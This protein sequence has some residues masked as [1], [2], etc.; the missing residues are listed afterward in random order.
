MLDDVSM[1]EDRAWKEMER[2][3][4]KSIKIGREILFSISF[5]IGVLL[6][7]YNY[8]VY[9]KVE[10]YSPIFFGRIYFFLF[11]SSASE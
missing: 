8:I 6:V 10:E 9:A 11:P 7:L 4:R 1:G 2:R 5:T 3:K